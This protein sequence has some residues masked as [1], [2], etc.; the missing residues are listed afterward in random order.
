[1]MNCIII[2]GF[3]GSGKTTFINYLL[4]YSGDVI[5]DMKTAVLINEF[6][7]VPV[8]GAMIDEGNYSMR[9]ITGGCICCTL[10]GMLDD[11]VAEICEKEKPDLLLVEA[12]GLAV[13]SEIAASIGTAGGCAVM[14]LLCVDSDQYGKLAGRLVIYD[15]QLAD[16]DMVLLTKSDIRSSASLA[17]VEAELQDGNKL[18][19]CFRSNEAAVEAVSFD[20][21]KQTVHKDVHE[22]HHGQDQA[23]QDICQVTRMI[24]GISVIADLEKSLYRLFVDAGT[25][26]YRV[27]GIVRTA[28][29]WQAVQYSD[30]AISVKTVDE[31]SIRDS[32]IVFIGKCGV[33]ERLEL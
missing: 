21:A 13:P 17:D 2:G 3:L 27:K 16:A 31:P 11:A 33:V 22:H 1:M 9:E 18:R 7:E 8:D 25:D 23:K 29:G 30:G 20:A 26:L 28:D 19:S 14:T 5:P 15:R 4:K 12:T 6:G 24:P 32:F 10:K